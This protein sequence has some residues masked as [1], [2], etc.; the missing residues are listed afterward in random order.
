LCS[1]A[2]ADSALDAL[3]LLVGHR[4]HRR[5]GADLLARVAFAAAHRVRGIVSRPQLDDVVRRRTEPRLGVDARACPR[6]DDRR[7]RLDH[8]RVERL[9]ARAQGL[10]RF[11]ERL[12]RR[13]PRAL[14]AVRIEDLAKGLGQ[15][16]EPSRLRF[17]VVDLGRQD[18]DQRVLVR[19]RDADAVAVRSRRRA[20]EVVVGGRVVGAL[21]PSV[22]RAELTA[23]EGEQS[24]EGRRL[25]C[26]SLSIHGSTG[27]P[28]RRSR[29]RR[30]ASVQRAT[31]CGLP[32][33]AL[34]RSR[35]VT[36]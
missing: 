1:V 36:R 4:R 11:V 2:I 35:T 14:R 15:H 10:E 13:R 7:L 3:V 17:D 20:G 19:Q 30:R 9:G 18:R 16:L 28:N 32:S 25:H 33:G 23:R 34:R 27:A 31:S 24:I 8:Q 26:S 5:A 22:E 21:H 12:R 29:R 6:P